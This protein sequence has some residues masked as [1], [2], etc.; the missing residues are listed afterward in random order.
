MNLPAART[1]LARLADLAAA[2]KALMGERTNEE[3]REMLRAALIE[4][5]GEGDGRW[6]YVR[7]FSAR[8]VVFEMSGGYDD[9]GTYQASYVIDDFD[10]SIAFGRPTEVDVRTDYVPRSTPRLDLSTVAA[11]AAPVLKAVAGPV[12]KAD[13][14]LRYTF[15]P[16]YPASP[17]TPSA[18]DLDAH[19]DFATAEDLQAAV[20]D[21][22][23]K[24]D[25]SIRLQH[26]GA[27]TKIGEWVEIV[28]WP[29]DVEVPLV[30]P[31]GSTVMK[32]YRA[33]TVFLG[34]VWTETGWDLVQKGLLTGYSLGGSAHRVDVEL[35]A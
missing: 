20:W 7:D 24:G 6:L 21:Y 8:W 2:R 13:S 33:G 12:V 35:A 32:S 15:A 34:T 17:D 10:G 26:M 28:S 18:A 11:S 14:A 25:R 29:F 1:A 27:E 4:R 19:G 3:T 16:M 5:Y 23:R 9:D 22:V 30:L 31:D